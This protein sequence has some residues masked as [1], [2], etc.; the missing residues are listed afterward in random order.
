MQTQ[1]AAA[2]LELIQ[3]V[4]AAQHDPGKIDALAA[5]LADMHEHGW[6]GLTHTLRQR[7]DLP[8][9]ADDAAELDDEDRAI[10][11]L[12]ELATAQPDDFAVLAAQAKDSNTQFAAQALAAVIYAATIG[13][14][15]ALETLAEL[16][17]AAD[18]PAAVA[19]SAALIAMIEGQRDAEALSHDLPTEQST[20]ILAVL[21]ALHSLESH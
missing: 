1:I 17:Q 9:T 10:L 21:K 8:T 7:F 14:R 4:L 6:L 5:L 19:T 16:H 11:E 15:E 18:T 12:L 2:H 20:L 13:E 3:C